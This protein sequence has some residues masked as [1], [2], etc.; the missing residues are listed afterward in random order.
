MPSRVPPT[1]AAMTTIT[2][3]TFTAR[4][5]MFGLSTYASNCM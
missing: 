4:F 1:S 5:M 2:P 3:G